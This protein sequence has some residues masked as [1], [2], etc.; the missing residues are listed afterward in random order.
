MTEN[1]F[2]RIAGAHSEDDTVPCHHVGDGQQHVILGFG[3][4][5]QISV[6]GAWIIRKLYYFYIWSS[7]L[8]S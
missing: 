1:K 3:R 8:H 4:M 7:K 5:V 6:A 2:N